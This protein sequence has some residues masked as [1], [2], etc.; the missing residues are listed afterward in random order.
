MR[1][2]VL[3]FCIATVAAPALAIEVLMSGYKPWVLITNNDRGADAIDIDQVQTQGVFHRIQG[4]HYYPATI[5]FS[6]T[7]DGRPVSARAD[8]VL[9]ATDI[10]CRS[11]GT[12][13]LRDEEYYTADNTDPSWTYKNNYIASGTA[14]WSIAARDSPQ[15]VIWQVL[16]KGATPSGMIGLDQ[17]VGKRFDI[18]HSAV[19][20]RIRNQTQHQ[21]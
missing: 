11:T 5:Q 2:I 19:L 8:Y 6:A 14:K 7:K 21:K 16:C 15:Y 12:Y 13:R 18:P 20:S 10:D 1:I 9:G 3:G 17:F 4:V